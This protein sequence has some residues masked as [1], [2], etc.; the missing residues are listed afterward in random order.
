MRLGEAKLALG[1]ADIVLLTHLHMDHAGELPGLFKARAVSGRG[2]VE[3]KIFGPGGVRST[4]GD[5][6]GQQQAGWGSCHRKSLVAGVERIDRG[7]PAMAQGQGS[8]LRRQ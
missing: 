1:R 2:P 5:Q 8:R 3:F 4:P 6:A 7:A